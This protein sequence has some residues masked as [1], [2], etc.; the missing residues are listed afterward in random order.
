[1]VVA[2]THAVVFAVVFYFTHKMVWRASMMLTMPA[3]EGMRQQEQEQQRN[4]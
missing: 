1:M 4:K 2:A 3:K